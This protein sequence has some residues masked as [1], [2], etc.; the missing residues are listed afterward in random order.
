MQ[1]S[2]KMELILSDVKLHDPN[3][4]EAMKRL[5]KGVQGLSMAFG[6]LGVALVN[7]A[8]AMGGLRDALERE[9]VIERDVIDVDGEVV[10]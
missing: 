8:R 1:T 10:E 7:C 6:I 4:Q 5:N 3:V 2:T 9:E